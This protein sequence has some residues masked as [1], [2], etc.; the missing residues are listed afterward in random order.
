M[1][2]KK[3]KDTGSY[4]CDSLF[5]HNKNVLF[6]NPIVSEPEKYFWQC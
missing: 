5:K 4:L 2:K 6:F 1:E 3:K